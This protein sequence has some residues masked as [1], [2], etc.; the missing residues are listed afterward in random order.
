VLVSTLKNSPFS[1]EWGSSIFAKVVAINDYGRSLES[2]E[3]NGA[4]IITYADKPTNLAETVSARTATTIT[5]TWVAG[6]LNGGSTV[7]DY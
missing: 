7:I 3:G 4:V 2:P 1:L 6:L 5:F